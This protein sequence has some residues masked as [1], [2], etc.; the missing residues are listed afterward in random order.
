MLRAPPPH[1]SPLLAPHRFPMNTLNNVIETDPTNSQR[2]SKFQEQSSIGKTV[3]PMWIAK[4][5]SLGKSRARQN[6]S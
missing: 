3:E 2:H 6:A 4:T 5:M 1:P